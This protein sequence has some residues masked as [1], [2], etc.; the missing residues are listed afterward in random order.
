MVSK[1]AN[2]ACS[3]PFLYFH[4]GKLFRLETEGPQDRRRTLGDD[5]SRKKCLRRIEFYWLCEDCA[6]SMTLAFDRTA[7]ISVRPQTAAAAAHAS[8]A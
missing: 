2:P 4:R 5:T 6:E 8:A 7:G 1:C 3:E